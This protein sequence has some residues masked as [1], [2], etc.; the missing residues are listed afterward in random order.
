MIEEHG[1]EL[2]K[3]LAAADGTSRCAAAQRSS[4]AVRARGQRR[5][6][7]TTFDVEARRAHRAGNDARLSRARRDGSF[8]MH[9]QL[10]RIV[11]LAAHVIVVAADERRP[12]GT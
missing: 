4:R 6:M 10:R 5:L 1:L 11:R 12:I 8:A 2:A 9:P 7:T 3:Q